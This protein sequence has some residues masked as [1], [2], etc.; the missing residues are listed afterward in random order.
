[1]KRLLFIATLFLA[2]A[3]QATHS[4]FSCVTPLLISSNSL[5]SPV[6]DFVLIDV[7]SV[8]AAHF[9]QY[10]LGYFSD[11]NCAFALSFSTESLN[12]IADV[13][14]PSISSGGAT[15]MIYK[16]SG[17]SS[18]TSYLGNSTSTWS[19][20]YVLRYAMSDGTTFINPVQDYSP[21]LS[22]GTATSITA[23][24]GI[25]DGGGSFSSSTLNSNY[26][27]VNNGLQEFEFSTW[28]KTSTAG[29]YLFINYDGGR[30]YIQF[31]TQLSGVTYAVIQDSGASDYVNGLT[32]VTD[33]QWHLVTMKAARQ[34]ITIGVELY[35]DGIRSGP[36]S[37][38]DGHT[39]GFNSG[40]P[41]YI[42]SAPLGNAPFVGSLDESHI[43]LKANS[44]QWHALEYNSQKYPRTVLSQGV[45]VCDPAA[46]PSNSLFFGG[47][48]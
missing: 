34:G 21:S 27:W 8:P 46:S 23:T 43:I 18:V 5:T 32:V 24:T 25:I 36:V 22:N 47:E 45:E 16:C 44:N 33:N 9:T 39:G 26:L 10:D 2:Q 29:T 48:F 37:G 14:V 42:G 35:V 20:G 40:S 7:S 4:G 12:S 6:T 31:Y 38:T 28:L 3:A 30:S 13:K 19:N 41:F 1:M 15:G 11:S 17:N